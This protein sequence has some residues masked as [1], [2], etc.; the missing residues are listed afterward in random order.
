MYKEKLSD[1]NIDIIRNWVEH[2]C[3]EG[4]IVKINSTGSKELDGKWFTPYMA[5]IHG[6]LGCL[7]TNGGKEVKDLRELHTDDLGYEIATGYDGLK[8]KTW[9]KMNISDPHVAMRVK[10]I[11]MLG[12]EGPKQSEELETRLHSQNNSSIKSFMS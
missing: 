11:E 3:Q 10:I 6:T 12:S 5:E 4:K 1:I 8:P 7:A 9:R 2:L